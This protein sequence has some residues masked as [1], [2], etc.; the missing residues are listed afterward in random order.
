MTSGGPAAAGLTGVLGDPGATEIGF[1]VRWDGGT[2][3]GRL[4][5]HSPS[6]EVAAVS[7]GVLAVDG[8]TASWSG[9]A[10][11]NGVTGYRYVATATDGASAG[12]TRPDRFTLSIQDAEGRVVWAA[13][14][15]VVRG[16]VVVRRTAAFVRVSASDR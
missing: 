14:W 11:W 4:A 12:S 9:A 6:A 16:D 3:T 5:L 13:D 10:R 15:P 7:V 1:S 8:P 2:P